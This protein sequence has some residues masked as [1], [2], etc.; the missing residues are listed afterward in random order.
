MNFALLP[1][2]QTLLK[3]ALIAIKESLKSNGSHRYLHIL[4]LWVR[5]WNLQY[6]GK[7]Q[8]CLSEE[9]KKLFAN[10]AKEIHD[11]LVF[12]FAS[13]Q[14]MNLVAIFSLI[15]VWAAIL[16]VILSSIGAFCE[17]RRELL[18]PAR[19][20]RIYQAC[21]RTAASGDP[22]LITSLLKERNAI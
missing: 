6:W 22:T 15:D 3:D 14:L 2:I 13:Q 19:K 20:M 18:L 12:L 9:W 4:V 10:T 11:I 5:G 8:E 21:E 17:L 16:D 7:F 1:V